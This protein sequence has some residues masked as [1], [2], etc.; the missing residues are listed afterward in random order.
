[1]M[2]GRGQSVEEGGAGSSQERVSLSGSGEELG[3]EVALQWECK[4]KGFKKEFTG[5][6]V[7]SKKLCLA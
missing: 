2:L 5:R 3:A 7:V 6:S 1:M 4:Q